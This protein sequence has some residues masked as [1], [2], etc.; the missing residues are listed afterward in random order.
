[1]STMQAKICFYMFVV[2]RRMMQQGSSLL[3][4]VAGI[5]MIDPIGGLNLYA[6]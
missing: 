2:S 5:E 6:I 3:G 1:M 4:R